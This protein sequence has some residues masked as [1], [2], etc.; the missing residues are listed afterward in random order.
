ML[1]CALGTDDSNTASGKR[2]GQDCNS[3]FPLYYLQEP[4]YIRVRWHKTG[5]DNT[6]VPIGRVYDTE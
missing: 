1:V 3:H 2:T 6:D 5:R 4:C